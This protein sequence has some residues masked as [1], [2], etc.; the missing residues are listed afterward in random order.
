MAADFLI[1]DGTVLMDTGYTPSIGQD[2]VTKEY[3]DSVCSNASIMSSSEVGEIIMW[4]HNIPPTGYLICDG[5]QYNYNDYPDLGS[6]LGA[7]AGQTFNVPDVNFAKNSKGNHT[8]DTEPESV[9]VHTHLASNHSHSVSVSQTGAHA[10]NIKMSAS[11]V[12]GT[13]AI[14]HALFSN[15]HGNLES[16]GSTHSHN[17]SSGSRGYTINNHTGVNQPECTLINFCIKY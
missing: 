7:S 14:R 12:D 10:H 4:P 9:G 16:A 15:S 11:I 6:L 2:I 13:G 5:S 3:V 17:A 1:S 8:L